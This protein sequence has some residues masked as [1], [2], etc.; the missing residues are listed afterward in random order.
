MDSQSKTT[1]RN[2]LAGQL[3]QIGLRALPQNLDD[4]LARA[5]WSSHMLLEE[6]C[7][8]EIQERSCRSLERRLRLSA[9]KSFKPLGTTSPVRQLAALGVREANIATPVFRR[10]F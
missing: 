5:R 7:R 2:D 3:Q 1:T 4:F 9:I 8:A 10:G 6:L